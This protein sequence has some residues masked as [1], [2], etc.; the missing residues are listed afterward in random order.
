MKCA[1]GETQNNPHL[2]LIRDGKCFYSEY[3]FMANA[4]MLLR[5]DVMTF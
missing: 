4:T 5:Y 1:T 2:Q 3:A